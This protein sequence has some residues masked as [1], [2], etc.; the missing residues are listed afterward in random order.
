MSIKERYKNPK[1]VCFGVFN[2]KR[3]NVMKKNMARLSGNVKCH[4]DNMSNGFTRKRT[5]QDSNVEISYLDYFITYD[6]EQTKQNYSIIS[7]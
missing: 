1:I 6:I 3:D 2:E 7:L 5:L 4:F